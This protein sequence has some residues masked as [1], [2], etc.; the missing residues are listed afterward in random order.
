MQEPNTFAYYS[1][2]MF[3]MSETPEKM[4][5]CPQEWREDGGDSQTTV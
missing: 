2:Q 5:A 3:V 1:K 4:A